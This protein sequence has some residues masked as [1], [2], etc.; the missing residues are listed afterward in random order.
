MAAVQNAHDAPFEHHRNAVRQVH[1]LFQFR[2]D[3]Q[4]RLTTSPVA[5]AVRS[6]P[7]QSAPTSR[8]RVGCSTTM[9]CR[10]AASSS[11]P[12][13]QLLQVAAG[14]LAGQRP[15]PRRAHTETRNQLC[16]VVKRIL[17]AGRETIA[18]RAHCRCAP[19]D[20]CY[21]ASEREGIDP[22]WRRSPGTYVEPRVCTMLRHCS[23]ASRPVHLPATFAPLVCFGTQVHDRLR[24]LRLPI[25][26]D[27]PAMPTIS[28][29]CTSRLHAPHLLPDRPHRAHADC[30]CATQPC[31]A[32][33]ALTLHAHAGSPRGRP[34]NC[35]N[36]RCSVV[37][38]VATEVPQ[39]CARRA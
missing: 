18:T 32:R 39:P 14:K 23:A 10:I 20:D 1:Q 21:P 25:A 2:G 17:V 16:G 7:I 11:R 15:H 29:A 9:A 28:P 4:N 30:R 31:R 3:K 24:Q 33:T 37:S 6:T 12:Y 38:F 13:D 35:A 22:T 34:S 5:A 36:A 19:E 27:T 8:P 26:I